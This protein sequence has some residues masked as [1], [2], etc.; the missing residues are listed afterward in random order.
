MSIDFFTLRTNF[1]WADVSMSY[2]KFSNPNYFR[3]CHQNDNAGDGDHVIDFSSS[4]LQSVNSPMDT[5]SLGKASDFVFSDRYLS[6]S[7]F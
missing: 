4:Q 5:S 1:L 7:I 2:I 6:C 3:E